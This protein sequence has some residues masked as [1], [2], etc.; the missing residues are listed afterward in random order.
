[1]IRF[2]L[3]LIVFWIVYQI[4]KRVVRFLT[5]VSR[6]SI[7]T[8][9]IKRNKSDYKNVEDAEFTEIKSED[10]KKKDN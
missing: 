10:N 3:Y 7:H 9:N 5:P 2:F 4:V 6:D 8:Q 1:M